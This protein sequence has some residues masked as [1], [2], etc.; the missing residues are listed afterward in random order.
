MERNEMRLLK[1]KKTWEINHVL[2]WRREKFKIE[3]T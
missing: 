2:K 3:P 1:V